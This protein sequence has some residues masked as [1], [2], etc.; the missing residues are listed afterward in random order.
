MHQPW[1]YSLD[2]A[3]SFDSKENKHNFYRER[4]CIKKFCHDV[5]ELA[6]KIINYE[7]KEMIPLMDYENKFYEK[8]KECHVCQKE[9]C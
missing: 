2:L 1:G 9:F 6:T 7:E 3:S 4:D 5:K 8:Q